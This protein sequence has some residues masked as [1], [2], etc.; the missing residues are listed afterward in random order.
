M[1]RV[2]KIPVSGPEDRFIKGQAGQFPCNEATERVMIPFNSRLPEPLHLKLR[3]IAENTPL[4]MHAFVCR[5]S[6]S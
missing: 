5:L 6:C 3:Y 2:P 1:K 4:S